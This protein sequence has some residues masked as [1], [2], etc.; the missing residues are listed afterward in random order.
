MVCTGGHGKWNAWTLWSQEFARVLCVVRALVV[1][2]MG[3]PMMSV[4]AFRRSFGVLVV[5]VADV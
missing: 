4:A 5:H 2:R 1:G 3:R